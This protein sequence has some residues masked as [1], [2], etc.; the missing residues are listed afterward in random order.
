MSDNFYFRVR[1]EVKGPFSREQI[2]SLIRKKRLGR[3]HELSADGVHW[4]RAGDVEGLFESVIPEERVV[5]QELQEESRPAAVEPVSSANESSRP[6]AGGPDDWFY[7]K[8]MNTHGPVSAK[9]LRAM[10]ATG[11]VLGTDRIWNEA[12][13]DWVPASHV[14]QFM[15]SI[16]DT[17]NPYVQPASERR[18][19]AP[20]AGFFDVFFGVS[21]DTA[22]PDNAF[23]KFPNLCRYVAIGESVFRVF[24]VLQVIFACGWLG[25]SVFESTR[26][27]SVEMSFVMFAVGI[28]ALAL[29][30]GLLWFA[31]LASMAMLE[32]VKV[33][34]RIEQNTSDRTSV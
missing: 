24:F 1:G 20:K 31:F 12:L 21:S 10:L 33:F 23:R 30:I 27:V 34:I 5:A 17:G 8:G 3:H 11:R 6:L 14:P 4:Q 25:F 29:L 15:G 16:Q 22:L 26:R 2:I 18:L 13:S 7:A 9:D 19:P 32:L 28:V